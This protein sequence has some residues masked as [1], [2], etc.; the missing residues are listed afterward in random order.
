MEHIENIAQN[1]LQAP[2]RRQL[3]LAAYFLLVV[4]ST[5]ILA[6]M[7]LSVSTRSAKVGRE[8]QTMQKAIIRLDREN[9]DLKSKLALIY[10]AIEME[11][12]AQ[13]LGF[14]AP[15]TD[16]VFYLSVPGYVMRMPVT[17]ASYTLREAKGVTVSPPEYT[18]SL[19]DWFR[20]QIQWSTYTVQNTP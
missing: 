20:R 6:G 2:W 12:R 1:Y 3:Q 17:L 7:Y 19:L 11:K 4:I 18:E 15:Q 10:S 16:Q 9:E 13:N 5:A 14:E 8:I